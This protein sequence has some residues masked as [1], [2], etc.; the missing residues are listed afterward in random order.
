MRLVHLRYDA[1]P[2]CHK[3][4]GIGGAHAKRDLG[5]GC[6]IGPAGIGIGGIRQNGD[7][8]AAR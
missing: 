2:A 3:D 7:E 5:D 1:A 8:I 4:Y 6:V